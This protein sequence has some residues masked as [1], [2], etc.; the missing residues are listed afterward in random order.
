MDIRYLG[1][2]AFQFK[3]G[4]RSILVDPYVKQND[5][6]DWHAENIT[7]IFVT[8]GHADHVGDTIEI[9]K[10]K[11]STVSAVVELAS[12]FS[13]EGLTTNRVN[14]GSWLNYPWGRAIFVPAFHSNSLPDGSYAGEAAGIIFD[15]EG[16][17]IY[18][19]GDTAL[20]SEMKLIKELYHPTIALLP[21]GGHYT[22]DV[23][24]AAVAAEWLGAKTVIPMHYNTFP[25]IRADLD[26]FYKLVNM[27]NTG[28]LIL[29]PDEVPNQGQSETQPQA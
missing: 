25:E 6:Y 26:M 3:V 13:K 12:Y 10:E 21:I 18:H 4:E 29:N 9:A 17:R 23:V 14:F 1:H 16:V 20:T 27:N 28:C 8:H 2:S 22:M 7:D 5:K 19:A 15:I 24:H 11:G